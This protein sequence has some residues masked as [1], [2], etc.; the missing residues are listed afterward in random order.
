MLVTG[1]DVFSR[2]MWVRGWSETSTSNG[3]RVRALRNLVQLD[4]LGE[5]VRTACYKEPIVHI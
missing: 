4:I 2:R 5:C 3:M 1:L